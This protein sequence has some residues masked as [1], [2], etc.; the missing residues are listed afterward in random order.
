MINLQLQIVR[1]IAQHEAK[2]IWFPRVMALGFDWVEQSNEM[3][4]D[5]STGI[6]NEDS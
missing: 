5:M 3:L 6:K 2:D 4:I 1:H